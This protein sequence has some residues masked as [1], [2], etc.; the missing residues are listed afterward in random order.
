VSLHPRVDHDADSFYE[1]TLTATDSG[2]LTATKTIFLYPET[3]T[4][5]LASEPAGAPVTYGE[6]EQAAPFSHVSAIGFETTIA[7]AERFARSG[8][9]W[10][11]ESWSD[12]GGRLHDVA[13]P[14]SGLDLVARYRDATS[15][16]PPPPDDPDPGAGGGSFPALPVDASGPALALGSVAPRAVKSLRGK[17]V[18]TAGVAS[19][20]VA[21]RAPS[22][23][24]RCRWWSTR[25]GRL[26]RTASACDRP[27]WSAARLSPRPG[28]AGWRLALGARLGP[29]RY[30]LL[31]RA[32]DGI[33]NA[34]RELADGRRRVTIAVPAAARRR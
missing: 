17:A 29:G 7:A 12:G 16:P 3:A 4:V 8:R 11:F 21:V 10:Q 34:T 28:A 22:R 14:Q 33:G 32:R 25:L 20:E 5:K 15:S 13:V 19:V 1:V 23:H 27:L 18:D 2:G 9:T 6:T 24:G 30:Q 31:F 26:G